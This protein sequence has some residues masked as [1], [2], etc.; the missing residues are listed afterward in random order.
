LLAF[1]DGFLELEHLKN[2]DDNVCNL[3][4]NNQSELGKLRIEVLAI[5]DTERQLQALKEKKSRL[6]K[7]KVGELVKHQVA[8]VK[9]KGLRKRG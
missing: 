8:L 6:E 1:L 7:D 2:E 9:E 3:L 5:K 4:L